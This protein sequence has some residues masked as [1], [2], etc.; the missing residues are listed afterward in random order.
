MNEQ[1]RDIKRKR[2]VLER[3]E[4]TGNIYETCRD[5]GIARSTFYVWQD[6]Y[7]EHGDAGLV[8][9]K[10]I[11]RGIVLSKKTRRAGS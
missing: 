8:R 10:P 3:V 11:A 4:R 7:R 2:C 9:R 6:A 1:E 5:F